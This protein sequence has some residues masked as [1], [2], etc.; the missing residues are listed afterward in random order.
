MKKR[1]VIRNG[2]DISEEIEQVK[3][4]MLMKG[5]LFIL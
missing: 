4:S 5:N 2:K 1:I 3:I